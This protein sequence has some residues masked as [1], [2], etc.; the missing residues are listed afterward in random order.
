MKGEQPRPKTQTSGAKPPPRPPV[1]TTLALGSD[2][3]DDSNQRR[4][5]RETLRISLRPVPLASTTIKL[6]SLPFENSKVLTI[7]ANNPATKHARHSEMFFSAIL[8]L[9]LQAVL[10]FEAF[11]SVDHMI[12]IL[13]LI[14]AI[15][16]S[17][18][19]YMWAF[20]DVLFGANRKH[21]S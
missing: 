16:L 18:P 13:F 7:Q 3:D 21:V 15:L 2:D 8:V 6:S 1:R 9:A 12:G 17:I 14:V 19:G 5:K 4:R 10:L 11:S 20:E